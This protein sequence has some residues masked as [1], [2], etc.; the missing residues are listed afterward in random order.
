MHQRYAEKARATLKCSTWQPYGC[1]VCCYLSI[2]LWSIAFTMVNE[3]LLHNDMLKKQLYCFASMVFHW[4]KKASKKLNLNAPSPSKDFTDGSKL[5]CSVAVFGLD[6]VNMVVH[7]EGWLLQ[8]NIMFLSVHQKPLLNTHTQRTTLCLKHLNA[9]RP[10]FAL[11][12][13]IFNCNSKNKYA[14]KYQI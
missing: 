11:C 5:N 7:A 3:H 13:L 12:K 2:Y 8:F 1:T 10:R 9:F 14:P 6:W 4:E